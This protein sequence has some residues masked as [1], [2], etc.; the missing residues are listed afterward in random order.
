[1]KKFINKI[2]VLSLL[3]C[4]I[5]LLFTGCDEDAPTSSNIYS[6]LDNNGCF[7]WR[8]VSYDGN[9]E[10]NVSTYKIDDM[11]SVSVNQVQYTITVTTPYD[12]VTEAITYVLDFKKIDNTWKCVQVMELAPPENGSNIKLVKKIKDKEL[13]A[14]IKGISYSLPNGMYID[15]SYI[16]KLVISEHKIDEIGYSDR[17]TITYSANI[18]YQK[19]EFTGDVYLNYTFDKETKTG[20]W[21]FISAAIDEYVR[22]DFS[23]TYKFS[24]TKGELY[25]IFKDA[26]ESIF[27]MNAYYP[28][29]DGKVTDYSYG[30]V[31]QD[32]SDF[33]KVPSTF[34]FSINGF[35]MNVSADIYYY[36]NNQGWKIDRL[37]NVKITNLVSP[38]IGTWEGTAGDGTEYSIVFTR[39]MDDNN[40]I[41][42]HV[43]C[44]KAGETYKYDS[45]VYSFKTKDSKY[46]IR[47]D[48]LKWVEKPSSGDEYG[49][50]DFTGVISKDSWEIEDKKRWI[51]T[52]KQ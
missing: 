11:K 47:V 39:E 42:A 8:R 24:P 38:I 29:R 14:A 17:V 44:K 21:K 3:I 5:C 31:E 26:N 10:K 41:L 35:V 30:E 40:R 22:S 33:L 46:N 12:Y 6:A 43:T 45:S 20:S 51:A 52:R 37:E 18:E 27:M 15:Y 19:Y 16:Y 49:Y 2:I 23:D 28:L 34:T 9:E 7:V 1:M 36:F 48:F 13:K 32:G 50:T 25:W 4:S